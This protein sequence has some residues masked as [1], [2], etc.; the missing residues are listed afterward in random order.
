MPDP[1]PVCPV[2]ASLAEEALLRLTTDPDCQTALHAHPTIEAAVHH[3][4]DLLRS[5]A[6]SFALRAGFRVVEIRSPTVPHATL[7]RY[8]VSHA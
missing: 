2:Y 1:T 7:A 6:V 5:Q 8:E 4:L 3:A